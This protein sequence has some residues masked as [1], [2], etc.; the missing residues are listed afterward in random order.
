VDARTVLDSPYS[1]IYVELA[2]LV[3]CRSDLKRILHEFD[4]WLEG[5]PLDYE[6]RR[7]RALKRPAQLPKRRRD[8]KPKTQG[9]YKP[10][11]DFDKLL[12]P[13]A[14]LVGV[15]VQPP[16]GTEGV[17]DDLWGNDEDP[18]APPP[19]FVLPH[20]EE[21]PELSHRRKGVI[22]KTHRLS[23]DD[24]EHQYDW[25]VRW[26]AEPRKKKT[27]ASS[28]SRSRR[29]LRHKATGHERQNRVSNSELE[30]SLRAFYESQAA[31]RYSR[32][33]STGHTS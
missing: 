13:P 3:E 2:L 8:K 5:R 6:L 9:P 25:S 26:K 33:T 20:E 24:R 19:V 11:V 1:S 30:A 15:T 32:I 12:M 4:N 17:F 10:L 27:A 21:S 22:K 29:K 28:V 16:A 7:R 18:N 31:S 23:R 14:H